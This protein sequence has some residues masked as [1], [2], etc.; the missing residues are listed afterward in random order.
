M[1]RWV[2]GGFRPT[3]QFPHAKSCIP[4]LQ[5]ACGGQGARRALLRPLGSSRSNPPAIDFGF[6]QP[7]PLYGLYSLD[8]ERHFAVTGVAPLYGVRPGLGLP[9]SWPLRPL[10]PSCPVVPATLRALLVPLE[11]AGVRRRGSHDARP[12]IWIL[13]SAATWLRASEPFRRPE[14]RLT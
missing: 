14:S 7:V 9:S 5:W 10:V 12:Q 4:P 1:W 6:P 13:S 11:V 2:K 8:C 3:W